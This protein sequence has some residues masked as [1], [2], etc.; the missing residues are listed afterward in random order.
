MEVKCM[1]LKELNERKGALLAEMRGIID[2]AKAEKRAM[3]AEENT[4]IE[5]ITA[6][7][8][9]IGRS[10]ENEE[11]AQSLIGAEEKQEENA[12]A[13]EKRAAR[14]IVA[15][16]VRHPG[17]EVRSGENT[18]SSVGSIVPSEFSADIIKKVT[19]LCGIMGLISVVNSK[20]IYKQIVQNDSYKITAGWVDEAA[21]ISASTAK[22]TTLD[23][24]HHK[25][26]A[27]VKMSLELINQND[28]DV[29][30]EFETQMVQDF[31]LKAEAGIIK[32]D[33]SGK[34]YGL[35]TSGTAYTLSAAALTSD[36]IIKIFHTLKAPY[37]PN[38]HWIMSND[39]LCKVRLLKDGQGQ[40][41]FHQGE[42]TNGFVGTILGR[43]VLISECMDNIADTKVPILYGDYGRAYKANLN[44][45]MTLQILMEKYAEIGCR[46]ILGILWLDGRPVNPEAYVKVAVD[47]Q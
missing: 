6:E 46:G 14:D 38:S 20:G 5:E 36:D 45:D 17:K 9:N 4:R 32:G 21:E 35:T 15:D 42:F 26:A 11:R 44:P 22:F 25:L 13:P 2:G 1:G 16:M 34:P 41:I 33:G 39:T 10:I 3:S 30:G 37:H 19:E 31:A 24:G 27:L 47:V 23:I 40:Y 43:P 18:V 29:V 28:F 8:S 7:V 12:G